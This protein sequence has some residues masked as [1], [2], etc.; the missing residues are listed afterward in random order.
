MAGL[1][2]FKDFVYDCVLRLATLGARKKPSVKKLL[3]VRLDE[4][5]D[6]MLWHRFLEESVA[7]FPDHAVVHFLGNKSWKDLYNAFHPAAADDV[8]W[9][10]KLSFKKSISYRLSVLKRVYRENYTTVINPT[11]SRDKRYDDSIVMAAKA[12]NRYGMAANTEARRSYEQGYD[13]GLYTR[14]FQYP[15]KPVFEFYRNRLF[16]AYL[17]GRH[18]AIADTRIDTQVLP[19]ATPGLPAM[20]FVVFPGSRSETRIWPADHFAEAAGYLYNRFGWTAVICGAPSDKRYAAAFREQYGYPCQDITG[21][22]SLPDM[23]KVLAGAKC[24]LSVD[25]GSVH[26]AA[27]AGC[28]V[29]GV[30]NGSQYGR[31]APYPKDIAKDFYAVYPQSI[32][33][34]LQDAAIVREH[35]EFVIQQPYASVTAGEVI[36]KMRETLG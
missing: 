6:F 26:M 5:G 13:A 20:Y 15:E 35:Y 22:T 32:Q 21:A 34:D 24:L 7:A 10:D 31:F 19:P 33:H 28:T 30:F 27:A 23:M 1:T 8:L 4:I 29:F 12:V 2:R 3:V 36:E 17:T 16:A 11:F 9:L 14:L 25:T 18:S